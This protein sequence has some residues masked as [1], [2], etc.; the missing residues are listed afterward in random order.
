MKKY[1]NIVPVFDNTR[2]KTVYGTLLEGTDD[3]RFAQ[4]SFEWE[5][6]RQRIRRKRQTQGLSFPE[7]SHWDWNQKIENAKRYP[8]VL[9]VFAIEYNGQ[10]QGLMIVDHVLFHAK[11]P[12]DSGYPL[13]YVRYI[14]NAPHIPFPNCFRGLD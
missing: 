13:L 12:P 8:D 9:T 1:E 5:I 6:E 14:E 7:H 2:R 10:I 3:K 4:T 11:L